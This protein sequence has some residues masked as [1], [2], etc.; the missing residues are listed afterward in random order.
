MISQD[1]REGS[2]MICWES[3]EL[4][5]VK[6]IDSLMAGGDSGSRILYRAEVYRRINRR[7]RLAGQ[8]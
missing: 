5:A 7:A 8:A 4:M 1:G 6:D 3:G 2:I